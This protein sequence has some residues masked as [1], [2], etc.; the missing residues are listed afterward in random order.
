MSQGATDNRKL[1]KGVEDVNQ[2]FK[3]RD[4]QAKAKA[5]GVPYVN[6]MTMPINPDLADYLPKA[7]AL[8]ASAALYFQVGKKLRMAVLD[9]SSEKLNALL[10]RLK[11]GGF[12]VEVSQCSEE[13]LKAGHKIYFTETY[14]KQEELK[15]VVAEEDLGTYMKEIET[16]KDLKAKIEAA[17]FDKALN[18]IQI[19]AYKTHSSDIHFEPEEKRIVVRFRIDGV[20]QTVFDITA[21]AYQGVLTEIKYLSHLKLNIVNMPQDGQYSFLVNDRQINVRVSTL[22][23]HYGEATVMRL[24]DSDQASVSFEDLGFEGADLERIKA[25]TRL[26][27]GMVLVTGPTGSGKTT[28]LYSMLRCIDTR[29]KKVITLEDPIE[30]NLPG[31]SQS[32]VEEEKGFTFAAGLRSILRQDPD[33]IMVGEIRDVETAETAVQAS[34]TGH[35]VFSTLHTNSAIESIPRLLNMGVRSFVLAPALNLIV[36]QRLVRKLCPSCSF[37]SAITETEKATIS[38]T[39]DSLQRRGIEVPA[40]PAELRHPKGCPVCSDTGFKGQVAVAEVLLFDQ[41]LR[42]LIL[43]NAPMPQIYEHIEKNLKMTSVREDGVLKVI[44]G[45]TTLEEVDRVAR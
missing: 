11:G 16:L 28:T 6:L 24:L 26:S 42:D 23:T 15:N 17:S 14:Q 19:G 13:S 32:Q 2:M 9:P 44:R 39:L 36:A 35:L 21:K 29:T 8:E 30:Y 43:A 3:E 38:E 18:Y 20:L 33:V 10:E 34:L 1:T 5:S 40:L 4:V 22:P 25:A 45:L 41:P 31:V 12:T 7:D 27:H 37:S